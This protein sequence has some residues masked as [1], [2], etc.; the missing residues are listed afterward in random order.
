MNRQTCQS[1]AALLG[2][3]LICL[4]FLFSAFGKITDW[5]KFEQ[6]MEQKGM[7]MVPL[8]LAGALVFE[9]VGG[10]SVLLGFFGRLGAV[11]LIVFLVPTTLIFHN[12]WAVDT[13]QQMAQMQNFMK[14]VAI[15]GGLFV[16]LALG[17]GEWSLDRL[18]CRHGSHI[19]AEGLREP[20]MVG[21]G[22][23]DA[24]RYGR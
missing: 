3:I 18:L 7:V 9:L 11:L 23:T 17:T 2:R 10:L 15:M 14:N 1:L 19:R 22:A 8:L 24:V 21:Q 12:F 4:I 5:S 20:A 6:M 13:A 16:V